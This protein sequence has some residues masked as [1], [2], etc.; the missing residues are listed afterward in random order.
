M[1]GLWRVV[2]VRRGGRTSG[3][4]GRLDNRTDEIAERERRRQSRG[5]A[6]VV[7]SGVEIASME[8]ATVQ[9]AGIADLGIRPVD[10]RIDN[11]LSELVA[12]DHR[13]RIILVL[14]RQV[15][16]VDSE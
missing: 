13:I 2:A 6:E 8:R 14:Q 4:C 11:E 3:R 1:D 10:A 7:V 12:D 5:R 9:V 15:A 16:C